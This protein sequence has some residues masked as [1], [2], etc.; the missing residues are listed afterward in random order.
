MSETRGVGEVRFQHRFCSAYLH[1]VTVRVTDSGGRTTELQKDILIEA[2][3]LASV[4]G[5]GTLLASARLPLR[6]AL[7]APLGEATPEK[8]VA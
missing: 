6:F 3:S 5:K 4:S 2:P 7:W 1:A 8:T